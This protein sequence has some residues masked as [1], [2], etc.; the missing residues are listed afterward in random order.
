MLEA[1][2]S[3]SVRHLPSGVGAAKSVDIPRWV[4]DGVEHHDDSLTVYAYLYQCPATSLR[5]V[6]PYI[7]QPRDTHD[8]IPHFVRV[9]FVQR[10]QLGSRSSADDK[11]GNP[12][13]LGHTET[14][15]GDASLHDLLLIV[16]ESVPSTQ[17]SP[18]AD[19]A[20]SASR[21]RP[22]SV[23]ELASGLGERQRPPA[24]LPARRRD[25]SPFN[26]SL[27]LA[28]RLGNGQECAGRR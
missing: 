1:P 12:Q 21:P 18:H 7:R 4:I 27:C 3:R 22:G 2:V 8:R 25:P 6:V 16:T 19:R 9:Q 15:D 23:A 28:C 26:F 14:L 17:C 10:G 11:P 24:V 5:V 20:D 13:A